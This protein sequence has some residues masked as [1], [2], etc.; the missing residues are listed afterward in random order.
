MYLIIL[1]FISLFTLDST[2]YASDS[3]D[4][5]QLR[6][7]L[8]PVWQSVNRVQI[9][10]PDATRF[11]FTQLGTGPSFSLRVDAAWRMSENS[12]L[13][14]LYAPL[15][16]GVSGRLGSDVSFQNT[17]FSGSTSTDGLYRF[18]SYRLTY[19][20]RIIEKEQFTLW[21]GITGKLRDAEIRLTQGS[22][23]ASRTNLGFVPLI[24]LLSTYRFSEIFRILLDIDALGAP[25]GRAEDIGLLMALRIHPQFEGFLGYRTL[26]GGSENGGNVYNFSWL[27]YAVI[28]VGVNF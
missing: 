5:F 26:E 11:D 20:Y 14:A 23:T 7:E 16:F 17:L 1:I 12:E 19:R 24:H 28:G 10:T 25:Q 6:L 2:A 15:S 8:A 4:H 18:N 13:R 9:P 22:I 21:A 27:H 3:K